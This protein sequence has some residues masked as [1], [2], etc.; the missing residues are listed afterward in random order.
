MEAA[1]A[2]GKAMAWL[3]IVDSTS[4]SLSVTRT[5]ENSAADGSAAL[6][7]YRKDVAV[8]DDDISDQLQRVE[9]K[10]TSSLRGVRKDIGVRRRR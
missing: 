6:A 5:T 4:T 10:R 1:P 7:G 8:G 2:D 9:L 3:H